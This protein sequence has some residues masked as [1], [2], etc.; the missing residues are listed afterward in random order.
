MVLLFILSILVNLKIVNLPMSIVFCSGTK[1]R[2]I[3]VWSDYAHQLNNALGDRQNLGHVVTILQ[4]MKH[5]I[6][7]RQYFF[8]S[9]IFYSFFNVI[10]WWKYQNINLTD[11]CI[12]TGKPIVSSMFC[13]TKLFINDDIPYIYNFKKPWV[14]NTT[15]LSPLIFKRLCNHL[16]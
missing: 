16:F 7:K 15:L 2:N 11:T 6:Y 1:L 8:E 5:K 14:I 9:K 13:A 3:T 12:P 10:H 4:F